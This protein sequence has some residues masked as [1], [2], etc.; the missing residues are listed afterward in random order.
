[1]EIKKEIANEAIDHSN[2][3]EH[4]EDIASEFYGPA[5]YVAKGLKE[6]GYDIAGHGGIRTPK[7]QNDFIGILKDE[8]PIQRSF[9]GCKIPFWYKYQRGHQ[10]GKLWLNHEGRKAKEDKRWVLEVYGIEYCPELS[11]IITELS[12]P[13]NVH[14]STKI[15]KDKPLKEG[16]TSDFH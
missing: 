6:N 15:E 4:L 8:E 11:E 7:P 16:H 5:H 12:R 1:M 14:V 2:L 9:L 3:R 10:I 13:Y